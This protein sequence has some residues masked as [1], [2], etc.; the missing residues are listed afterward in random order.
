MEIE[1]TSQRSK[2]K[3][4]RKGLTKRKNKRKSVRDISYF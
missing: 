2:K 4:E 1:E 3:K